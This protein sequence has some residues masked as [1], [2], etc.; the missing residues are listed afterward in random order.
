MSP[1]Q[2]PTTGRKPDQWLA[3][4][5]AYAVQ[6]LIVDKQRDR[7]LLDLI[8]SRPDWDIDFE[9]GDA[10]VFSRVPVSGAP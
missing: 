3:V 7:S 10:A 8:R 1:G 4:L 5:D 2:T 6:F 9:D